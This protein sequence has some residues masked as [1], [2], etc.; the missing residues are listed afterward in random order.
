MEPGAFEYQPDK[1]YSNAPGSIFYSF[2]MGFCTFS[3]MEGP[4]VIPWPKRDPS[5][6]KK[7]QDGPKMA[8]RRS[9]DDGRVWGGETEK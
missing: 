5:S 8:S 1:K 9:K 2:L 6:A 3:Y 4:K 7:A